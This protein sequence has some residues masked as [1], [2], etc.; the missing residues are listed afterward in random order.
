MSTA[1]TSP[2]QPALAWFKSSC[3]GAEG[4]DCI[5][6]AVTADTMHVRDSKRLGGPVLTIGPAAWAGFVE[7]AAGRTA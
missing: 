3:S 5:E 7:L 6:V 4:G 1:E 2:A